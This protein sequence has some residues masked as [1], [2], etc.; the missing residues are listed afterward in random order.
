MKFTKNNDILKHFIT[1]MSPSARVV[2]N[3][4]RFAVI[5]LL[6]FLTEIIQPNLRTVALQLF[7]KSEKEKLDNLV[8][9]MILFNVNYRQEKALDG[10]YCYVL[11]P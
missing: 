10:Q 8:K 6:P 7:T 3:S 11:E 2:Y 9:T 1:D 4:S 5:D